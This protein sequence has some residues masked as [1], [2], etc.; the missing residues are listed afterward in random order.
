MIFVN[1]S[2]FFHWQSFSVKFSLTYLL[3]EQISKTETVKDV[4]MTPWTSFTLLTDYQKHYNGYFVLKNL[5][6][7]HK[8]VNICDKF[9]ILSDKE[10]I[11]ASLLL[12]HF[13]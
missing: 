2:F 1:S 13:A 3:S 10:V 7:D 12:Y 9:C 8:K 4:L 6:K 5:Q 11:L